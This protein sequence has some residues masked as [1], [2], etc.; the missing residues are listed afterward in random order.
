MPKNT[1]FMLIAGGL[2]LVIGFLFFRRARSITEGT[3]FE[4]TGL[5]GTL[6]LAA[7]TASAGVLSDLGETI[8]GGLADVREAFLG[9]PLAQSE[10]T[11]EDIAEQLGIFAG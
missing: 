1:Q 9:D 6:G 8:G 2:V 3:D 7:D 10:T 5:L 11:Q 4:G